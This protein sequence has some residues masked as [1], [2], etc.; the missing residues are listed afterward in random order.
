MHP[1]GNNN[2]IFENL[3][4]NKCRALNGTVSYTNSPSFRFKPRLTQTCEIHLSRCNVAC[5]TSKGSDQ[6]AH[7]HNLIRAFASPLNIISLLSY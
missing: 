3:L 7:T 1:T 2:D 6:P 5:A 4:L